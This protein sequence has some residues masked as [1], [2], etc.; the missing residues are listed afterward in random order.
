MSSSPVTLT[1]NGTQAINLSQIPGNTQI[2]TPSVSGEYAISASVNVNFHNDE[3]PLSQAMIFNTAP[4]ETGNS[5][6]WYL[7]V[8]NGSGA[9]A[10]LTQGCPVYV[11]L[12]DQVDSTDN[13]GTAS[14]TFTLLSG[15]K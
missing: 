13:T 12:V 3:L 5:Y 8:S 14:V 7:V 9:T 2:F 1:L 11:F 6:M 10:Q 4:L 15:S